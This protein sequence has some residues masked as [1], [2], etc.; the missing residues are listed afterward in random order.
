MK[1]INKSLYERQITLKHLIIQDKKMIGIQFYP[2]KIIQ[3]M[4]KELPNPRWSEKYGMVILPNT[5]ENVNTIINKFKGVA[6]V[7]GQYFFTNRPINKGT[8]ELSVDVYRKRTPL[9]DWKFVPEDF[10]IK[11]ETRKYSL[12]TAK[13][14]ISMFE[15]FINHYKNEE[16][17]MAINEEMI[18]KYIQ[19]LVQIGLSDSYV[20]QSINSIKFYYEVVKEMPNRFY[21]VDRPIPKDP[22]P[23]VLSKE[24]ISK[25]IASIKNI[26]H[27][28]LVSMLYATGL[29]RTEL[30][31]LKIED[32]DSK[33]MTIRVVEGKGKKDRFTIL[34]TKLLVDLRMYYLAYKPQKYLF[35]GA[36]GSQYSATSLAKVVKV[37][38]KNAKIIK[39]VTP[40]M[41]RHSFATH[42]LEAGTD[43]RTIQTLL[44]H[45]SLET[46]QM[47]TYVATTSLQN[48]KNPLDSL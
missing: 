26:K 14:Y 4:I 32:L 9:S 47:Y 12:N 11:L 7:N 30:L 8:E 13:V 6:W 45:N 28:C 42:L 19:H 18:L 23:K 48:I 5:S 21:S 17:F 44:G 39:V 2:N 1:T 15:K 38:A 29:R 16:N 37:A 20:N 40:H 46:T 36:E 31:N 43:L 41:L 22:L 25:M 34:S 24:D 3:A 33:R 27:K 35:E 10:L